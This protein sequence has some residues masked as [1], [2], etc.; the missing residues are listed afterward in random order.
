M[1]KRIFLIILDICLVVGVLLILFSTLEIQTDEKLIAFRYSDDFSEFEDELSLD[2]NYFYYAKK[3]ISIHN[4]EVHKILFFYVLEMDYIEGNYC[5]TQ[6]MLEEKDMNNI[7]ENAEIT[8][9]SHNIDLKK[10]LKGKEA[11]VSNTRYLS[12]DYERSIEYK[13]GDK[14]GILYVFYEN[15]MTVIQVGDSDE[16]PRYIA[17]R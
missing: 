12:N 14:Y 7:I 2:E 16:G 8:Y 10:L 6:F 5:D 4:V 1:K 13:L 11:I 9:N 17:Y 3:D 15:D